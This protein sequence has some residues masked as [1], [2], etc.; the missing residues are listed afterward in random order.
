[1]DRADFP[2]LDKPEVCVHSSACNLSGLCGGLNARRKAVE[3]VYVVHAARFLYLL[4]HQVLHS[5]L[6]CKEGAYGQS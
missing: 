2:L 6:P 5:L 1:M 4:I 3:P